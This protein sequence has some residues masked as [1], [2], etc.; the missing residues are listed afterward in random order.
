MG[1]P[2]LV[3]EAKSDGAGCPTLMMSVSVCFETAEKADMD[4]IDI[5]APPCESGIRMIEESDSVT[6]EMS[7]GLL[8]GDSSAGGPCMA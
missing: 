6:W 2:V 3:E 4:A 1:W 8:G 7:P 5:L